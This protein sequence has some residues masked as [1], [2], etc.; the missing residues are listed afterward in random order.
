MVAGELRAIFTD[1][2]NRTVLDLISS[3][4]KPSVAHW[5]SHL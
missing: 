4:R 2:G 3:R 5:L 1:L